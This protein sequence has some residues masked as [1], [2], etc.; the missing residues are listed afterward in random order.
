MTY[1]R[2]LVLIFVLIFVT[3]G[4]ICHWS[5]I[6]CRYF[7]DLGY[8]SNVSNIFE[9]LDL[10]KDRFQVVQNG[11]RLSLFPQHQNW[12]ATTLSHYKN[13]Y[14]REKL[15]VHSK[16]IS[17]V[18]DL[19]RLFSFTFLTRSSSKDLVNYQISHRQGSEINITK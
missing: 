10:S 6:L 16:K 14:D 2:F 19:T 3:G 7:Y 1:H 15:N 8:W 17:M 11:P 9:R 4:I 12:H 18:F 13:T 5:R